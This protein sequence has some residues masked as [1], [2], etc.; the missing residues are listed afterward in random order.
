M[1]DTEQEGMSERELAEWFTEEVALGTQPRSVSEALAAADSEATATEPVVDEPTPVVDEA[2]VVVEDEPVQPTPPGEEEPVEPEALPEGEVEEL[3]AEPEDEG[4]P[5]VV[6]AKKKYGDDPAKW[7]KAAYEQE[8]HISRLA[9]EKKEAEEMAVQWYEYSQQV[10][11]QQPQVQMPLSAKEEAWADQA[12]TNPVQYAYQAV[13]NGNLQLYNAIIERVAYQDPRQASA[14]ET[15]VR[16]QVMAAAE[17]EE[18]NNGEPADLTAALG[19]AVQRAGI[20]VKV[21]GQAMM[22]K[23]ADLGEY[24]PYV[25]AILGENEQAREMALLAVYDMVRSGTLTTRTVRDESRDEKIR[26]EAELRKEA[27]GVV[28]GG[29]SR[30]PPQPSS[31]FMDAMQEEWRNRG[32]WSSED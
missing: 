15:E 2:P 21:H 31:S 11:Q 32:Q 12:M 3:P 29:G 7:A 25:Q 30:N 13:L 17:A 1:S 10:E 19:Q 27:A 8:Q 14:V 22:E 28:T 6:W 16:L 23:I 26:R 24:S 4:D 9:G 20:D 18:A 5:N